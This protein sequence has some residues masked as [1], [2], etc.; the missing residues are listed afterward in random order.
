MAGFPNQGFGSADI[1]LNSSCE[2]ENAVN[3]MI[4][5]FFL[6]TLKMS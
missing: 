3:R 6:F 5:R 2:N 4:Y 1:S